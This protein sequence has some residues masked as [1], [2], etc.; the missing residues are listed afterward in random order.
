MVWETFSVIL[1]D[2]WSDLRDIWSDLGDIWSDLGDIWSAT[3]T[4]CGVETHTRSI[5]HND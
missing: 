5:P 3:S 4:C 2:I 1:G